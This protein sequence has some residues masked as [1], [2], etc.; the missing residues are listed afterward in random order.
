MLDVSSFDVH[1]EL[2]EATGLP[3]VF[4]NDA[5]AGAYGEWRCGAARG[6]KDVFFVTMGTGIGAGLIQGTLTCERIVHAAMEEDA[7]AQSVLKETGVF[8]GMA[9]SNII[10]LLNVEMV[11][12]GGGVMADGEPMLGIVREETKKRTIASASGCCRIVL[13]E[14]GQDAGMI[15][16]AMLARDA[17][18]E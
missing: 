7:L 6:Y 9:I 18:P 13:A 15:G 11:V 8:L 17:H 16:A 10:N 4:D 3:V 12:L 14:L 2:L 1:R 5:N